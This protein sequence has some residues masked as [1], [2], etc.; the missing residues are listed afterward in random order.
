VKFDSLEAEA[1]SR[2]EHP[3]MNT[4]VDDRGF[5]IL[6]QVFD[7][8][9]TGGRNSARIE[10]IS[11]ITRAAEK[12]F[13]GKYLER[14]G[15]VGAYQELARQVRDRK[16]TSEAKQLYVGIVD[17]DEVAA[18]AWKAQSDNY[19]APSHE[20]GDEPFP[21]LPAGKWLTVFDTHFFRVI[22][23][24]KLRQGNLDIFSRNL[25]NGSDKKV[26]HIEVDATGTVKDM[27]STVDHK[28]NVALHYFL[29]GLDTILALGKA[30]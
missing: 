30:K 7:Q 2:V 1:K 24:E 10:L 13:I 6:A 23:I 22:S 14:I 17:R 15:A 18:R 29:S 5:S 25:Q 8:L 9:E 11:K 4:G 3:S 27:P 12:R 26:Y 20:V 28:G 21:D 19:Y 16:I